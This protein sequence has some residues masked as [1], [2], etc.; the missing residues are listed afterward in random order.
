MIHVAF[1]AAHAAEH[2]VQNADSEAANFHTC[3]HQ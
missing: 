1:L 3:V 2:S